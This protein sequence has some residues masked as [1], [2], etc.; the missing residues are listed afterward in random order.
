MCF[1]SLNV[2]AAGNCETRRCRR[3]NE[4]GLTPTETSQSSSFKLF[5]ASADSA[6]NPTDGKTALLHPFVSNPPPVA[7]RVSLADSCRLL[8]RS[9]L[10]VARSSRRCRFEETSCMRVNDEAVNGATLRGTFVL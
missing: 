9:L 10:P 1:T 7:S 6:S 4:M 3:V 5:H 8:L 2:H